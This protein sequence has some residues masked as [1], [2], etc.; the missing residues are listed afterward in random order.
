MARIVVLDDHFDVCIG[1]ETILNSLGHTVRTAST[2]DEAIDFC[3]LFQ[4]DILITDWDLNSD[5]NGCEVSEA[6]HAANPNGKT[7]LISGFKEAVFGQG[8]NQDGIFQ[9]LAKPFSM[10]QLSD[11]VEAAVETIATRPPSHPKTIY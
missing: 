11:V 5:Y 8:S 6:Y 10:S 7:I 2:G 4:P 3:Y 1:I 9:T